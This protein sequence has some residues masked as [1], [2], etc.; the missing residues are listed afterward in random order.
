MCQIRFLELKL[1]LENMHSTWDA[2][3]I[4]ADLKA[5]KQT[6]FDIPKIK[7]AVKKSL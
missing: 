1:K 3:E 6:L 5:E 4:K 7:D 2:A